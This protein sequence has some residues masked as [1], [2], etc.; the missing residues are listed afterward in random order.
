MVGRHRRRIRLRLVSTATG[1]SVAC[2]ISGRWRGAK[3][4]FWRDTETIQHGP[5]QGTSIAR[6]RTVPRRRPAGRAPARALRVESASGPSRNTASQ[7]SSVTST[8]RSSR[9]R[10]TSTR[11]CARRKPFQV[12]HRAGADPPPRAAGW[13]TRFAPA[14]G[15][16]SHTLLVRPPS[17][18]RTCPVTKLDASLARNTAAP[19]SSPTSPQRPRGVR[20]VSHAENAGS[21]TRAALRSVRK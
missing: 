6:G 3:V 10:S 1:A 21:A 4:E 11:G 8:S 5:Q 2:R 18:Y 17:T 7:P 12:R 14:M 9:L 16:G 20:L 13:A 19:A 15:R